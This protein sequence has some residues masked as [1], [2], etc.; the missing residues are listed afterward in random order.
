VSVFASSHDSTPDVL[1]P[2]LLLLLLPV[3]LAGGHTGEM[4]PLLQSLVEAPTTANCDGKA[5]AAAAAAA[6][7]TSYQQF[8]LLAAA[9]DQLSHGRARDLL[10][11]L[12][13]PA[14]AI[15]C[16]F[17]KRSREV[18]QGWFSTCF[19]TLIALVHSIRIVFS[20]RPDLILCNGPGAVNNA[21]LPLYIV[22]MD[23]RV[24]RRCRC[25]R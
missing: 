20:T 5:A 9:T 1:L 2:L 18:R 8:T 10:L 23:G 17:T 21:Q 12:G 22:G 16:V 11:R 4:I 3:A 19:T 15:T 14:Q 7:S 24:F 13:V 6:T 25:N